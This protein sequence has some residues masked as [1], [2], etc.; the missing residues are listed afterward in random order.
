MHWGYYSPPPPPIVHKVSGDRFKSVLLYFCPFSSIFASIIHE[1]RRAARLPLLGL[2]VREARELTP[3][4]PPNVPGEL[5]ALWQHKI[6]IS[7]LIEPLFSRLSGH[8]AGFTGCVFTPALITS[9]LLPLCCVC[10]SRLAASSR[11]GV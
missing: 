8:F 6:L 9:L 2:A 1:M 3:P 4:P 7:R 11:S 5:T 10:R